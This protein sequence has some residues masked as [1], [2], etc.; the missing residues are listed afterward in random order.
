MDTLIT[1]GFLQIISKATRIQNNNSSLID[2]ILTNTNL[3]AYKAGTIIDDLSDHFMNFLVISNY[4]L[5][6]NTNKPS[7]RRLINDTNTNALKNALINT[8]WQPVLTDNDV[9]SSFNTF[10]RIF[11]SL[12]D[13]HFPITFVRFNKNKHR[14]NA[15]MNDNLLA[16]RNS[17][18]NL[19]KTYI[20]TK[21]QEDYNNYIT[22]RNKYNTLLRQNKQKYYGDKFTKNI[23]KL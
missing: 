20:S 4:K 21:R 19:H 14:I 15:F 5:A 22:Q 6:K 16:E 17:K 7:S 18:L 13:E 3:T 1:N 2:H 10:W 9:D 8:D 12:Y 11:S 23:K